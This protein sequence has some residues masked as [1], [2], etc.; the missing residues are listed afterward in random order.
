MLM[1][2]FLDISHIAFSYIL[3]RVAFLG[4]GFWFFRYGL[5]D[6]ILWVG[7]VKLHIG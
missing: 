1:I 6:Y 4:A 3:P 5:G 2:V 7:F